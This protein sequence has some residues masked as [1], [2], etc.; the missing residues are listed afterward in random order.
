MDPNKLIKKYHLYDGKKSFISL[1]EL[2]T[3]CLCP[4]N[5]YIDKGVTK[6]DLKILNATDLVDEDFIKR[7][8]NKGIYFKLETTIQLKWVSHIKK[9]F[10]QFKE[11]KV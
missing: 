1:D 4:G 11:I 10:Q 3:F 9:V 5:I 2:K 6:K 8:D 7:F